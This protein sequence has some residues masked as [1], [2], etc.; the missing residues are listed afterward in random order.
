MSGQEYCVQTQTTERNT[1][2]YKRPL[3]RGT[4]LDLE[5]R[6]IQRAEEVLLRLW[7]ILTDRYSQRG[8]VETRLEVDELRKNQRHKWEENT[9]VRN[10]NRTLSVQA[11]QIER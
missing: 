8:H 1:I 10:R 4:V 11:H 9:E 3:Q 2:S 5:G 6:R 7:L